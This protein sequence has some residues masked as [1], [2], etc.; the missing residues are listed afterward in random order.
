MR[1]VSYRVSVFLLQPKDILVWC[2]GDFR[3]ATDVRL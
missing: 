2:L 3:L 1:S